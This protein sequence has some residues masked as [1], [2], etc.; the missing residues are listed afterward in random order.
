MDES[1]KMVDMRLIAGLGTMKMDFDFVEIRMQAKV[2]TD[3]SI[4][5]KIQCASGKIY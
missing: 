5:Q 2:T 1:K 4:A 3:I